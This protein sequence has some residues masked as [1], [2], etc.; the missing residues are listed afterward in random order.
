MLNL[1]ECPG[2]LYNEESSTPERPVPKLRNPDGAKSPH[3]LRTWF[4]TTKLGPL[5]KVLVSQRTCMSPIRPP[6]GLTV[7]RIPLS[8]HR[9]QGMCSGPAPKRRCSLFPLK[10]FCCDLSLLHHSVYVDTC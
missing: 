3:E 8:G 6:A 5:A 4:R 10:M 1:L 9:P 7:A 2:R